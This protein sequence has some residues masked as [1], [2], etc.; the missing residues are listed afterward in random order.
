MSIV[1]TII[2]FVLIF[3]FLIL[4]HELGHFTMAKRAGIKVEEFGFGLPP[5]LWGKKKGETI[6]SVNM[7]PFGG[8]VRMFGE[9]ANDPKMLRS[10]R[11]FVAKSMRARTLVIIAGVVMNFLFAWLLLTIGFTVG[12]QPLLVPGDVLDSIK[13]GE[14]V[15]EEGVMIEE[16]AIDSLAEGLGFE[17]GDVFY[18]F[19]G[20]TFDDFN[21]ALL[22]A[23]EV[24]TY[25]VLREGKMVEIDIEEDVL[26]ADGENFGVALYDYAAFP[27][28][29]IYDL[30][31]HTEA[32]K[33]GLRPGDILVSI[34]GQQIFDIKDYEAITR[35]S[36][37]LEFEVVRDGLMEPFIIE[38]TNVRRVVISKLIPGG[39]A[40]EAGILPGDIVVSINGK[41]IYDSQELISFVDENS[42]TD[43]AYL[44]D[45]D[46]QRIF[47]EISP[48]NGKIGVYLSELMSY[49]DEAGVSIFNTDLLSSVVEVKEEKY[50]FYQAPV[51]AFTESVRLSKMTA[52]MFG[53][54]LTGLI[55]EGKVPDS[56]AGPVGIAQ[57]THGF[58]QEGWMPLLRFVAILSLSLAVINILPFPALDGGRLLFIAFE[59]ITGR[60]VKQKYEAMIHGLGYIM[61]LLLILAVTYSDIV[62]LF[63]E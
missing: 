18:S 35:G 50:P 46:G 55:S 32:Y 13:N 15:L 63:S 41:D 40:D 33:V 12:M 57:M 45:R 19:N 27:R 29:E 8:F 5:R 24:G 39:P 1:I 61:I 6:Y 59:F 53:D 20:D 31:A 16:V 60:R 48:D 38:R 30:K 23:F 26:L 62:R 58:V 44:I 4:I 47:Y 22:D 2:A 54:F 36:K 52:A 10:K 43:L 37:T 7:I 56:V 25:S 14:I 49:D 51:K 34:N 17:A 9:D 21:I 3:S 42:G 11:S 28:V